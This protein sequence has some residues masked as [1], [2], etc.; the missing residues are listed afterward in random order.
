MGREQ[1]QG[2][3]NRLVSHEKGDQHGKQ[4]QGNRLHDSL[5]VL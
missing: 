5:P 1:E 3:R 4:D 2:F